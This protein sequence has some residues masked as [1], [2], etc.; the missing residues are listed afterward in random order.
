MCEGTARGFAQLEQVIGG[1]QC[2][3]RALGFLSGRDFKRR[4]CLVAHG[5]QF[6]QPG[7]QFAQPGICA[8]L[9]F[10]PSAALPPS[11]LPPSSDPRSSPTTSSLRT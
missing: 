9:P 1:Q 11:P 8:M 10:P 3:E 6:A 4:S 7:K 2:R 5:K